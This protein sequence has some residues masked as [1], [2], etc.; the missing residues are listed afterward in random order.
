MIFLQGHGVSPAFAQKIYKTYGDK[1]IDQMQSNPYKIARD[2]HGIGFKTAD[3]IAQKLGIPK[4]SSERIDAGIEFALLS[5]SDEGHVCMPLSEFLVLATEMLETPPDLIHARFDPLT[6]DKRIEIG[7]MVFEGALA[8]FIWL[9]RMFLSE[10]GIAKQIMR[11]KR[12]ACNLRAVDTTR[13]LEW[14]QKQLHIE[15]APNQADAVAQS[16]QEKVQIITG[17]PGTGKSTITK[18]VLAITEKTFLQNR[19][20]CT[21]RSRSEADDRDHRKKGIHNPQSSG[22]RFQDWRLQKRV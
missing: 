18:A 17:G 2:I 19:S 9:R 3:A 5:C 8:T 11:L 1:S 21:D 6:A 13:A 16:L 15:L 7:Q 12:C 20:G 10:V 22:V 4:D 14:V